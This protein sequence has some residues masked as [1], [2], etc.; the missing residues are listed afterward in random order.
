MFRKTYNQRGPSLC[1]QVS[2]TQ[3]LSHITATYLFTMIDC[4][5]MMIHECGHSKSPFWLSGETDHSGNAAEEICLSLIYHAVQA[6]RRLS[7]CMP[8]YR[9]ASIKQMCAAFIS[10]LRV[11]YGCPCHVC[12][13]YS[14]T[15]RQHALIYRRLC[16]RSTL[17]WTANDRTFTQ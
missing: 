14:M 16:K 5:K 3:C 1:P 9:R 15:G 4:F 6:K 17:S 8:A 7:K 11:T 10:T 2:F 13:I 12:F